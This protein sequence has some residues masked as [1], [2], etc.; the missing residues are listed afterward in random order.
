MKSK[1][2]TLIIT[3]TTLGL[4]GCGDPYREEGRIYA[5][6]AIEAIENY[7]NNSEENPQI[8]KPYWNDC[9]NEFTCLFLYNTKDQKLVEAI[10]TSLMSANEKIKHPG[11][12]LTVY[13]TAHSE[14]KVIFREITI[15]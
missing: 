1:L 11:I 12:K 15:K 5:K 14:P 7:Q 2:R 9:G 4:L 8:E 3:I 13:S 6:A 10:V